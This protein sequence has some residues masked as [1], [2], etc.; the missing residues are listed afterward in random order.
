MGAAMAEP[1]QEH[2]GM[3]PVYR[4]TLRV[5]GQ[6]I[7]RE[8]RDELEFRKWKGA[9]ATQKRQGKGIEEMKCETLWR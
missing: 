9:Y 5:R 6:V 8:Y 4:I 1:H 2:T 7:I 3:K